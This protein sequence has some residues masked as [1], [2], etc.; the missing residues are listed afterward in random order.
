MTRISLLGVSIAALV[1]VGAVAGIVAVNQP[2]SEACGS[3]ASAGKASSLVDVVDNETADAPPIA[4]F[5]TPLVTRGQEISLV[6]S[7]DGLAAQPGAAVD[8]QVAAYLGTTGEF[9]TASSFVDNESVRRVVDPQSEDFF[10]RSLTCARAGDRLV[11]TDTIQS[12]FG[13]IPED[14][15]VQNDSTVVVVIDVLDSFLT[16]A[17]GRTAAAQSGSPRVVMHPDGYHG[18]SVPM[19]PPPTTLGV[20]TLKAGTGPLLQAGDTAVVHFT[21]VVWETRQVFSSSFDQDI[22][23]DVVLV[24]GSTEGATEGVI[25]GIFEGLVGQNVG[26]QVALVVPPAAGYPE[27][28]GP[29]GAPAGS[30]LIYVFDIVG[31]K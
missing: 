15:L 2:R 7:G 31:V 13:P 16:Q 18:V 28:G 21:G 4:T 1:G 9:L 6:S 8:F 23:L 25:S 29:Q 12:V 26:S 27:G 24:D 20:Y 11:V 19:G 14:E 22:P 17:D 10:S 5:P 3:V 30:T